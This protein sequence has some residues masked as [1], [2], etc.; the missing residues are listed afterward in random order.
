ML[1]KNTI[2]YLKGL[3]C[4]FENA[5]CASLARIAECSHD[6]LSRVLNNKSV[7]WQTL[8][9]H[10]IVRTF[11]NLQGGYLMI[12]DTVITKQ[13]AKKIEA[14][15]WI[16]CSKINRSVL[17]LNLVLIAWSNGNITIPLALRVYRKDNKKT[18]IDLALELFSY[19]KNVLHIKPEF[20][21]FDCWYSS[22]RILKQCQKYG[23]TYVTVLKKNRKLNGTQVKMLHRNP[24]WITTGTLAGGLKVTIVRHG[25]KYFATNDLSF[26]KK[27]ILSRYR[28]RWTIETVF[29]ALHSKLGFDECESRS[30]AAQDAHFHLC[31]MTFCVLEKEHFITKRTIYEIKQDC[32]FN[33][34]TADNLLT[35]L[36]FQG[37]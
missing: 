27:E 17:G 23:W 4:V 29:R 6:S 18:K 24:Y 26:S 35:K 25:K 22:T 15:S 36:H 11:G 13:F 37:A 34:E 5:N 10:L 31:L 33:F 28:M 9:Q 21:T 8:L 20:V 14:L 7:R 16:F 30:F 12:D 32:S 19:A 3:L 1:P 2:E